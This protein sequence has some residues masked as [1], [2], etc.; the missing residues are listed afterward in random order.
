M[1]D[2]VAVLRKTIGGLEHNTPEA[3]EKVFAKARNAIDSKLASMDPPPPQVVADRQRKALEDAIV[4]VRAEYEPPAEDNFED[5]LGAFESMEPAAADLAARKPDGQES[6]GEAASAAPGVGYDADET[7]PAER[8]AVLASQDG[9]AG[10]AEPLPPHGDAAETGE[11][12]DDKAAAAP[13]PRPA[14]VKRRRTGTLAIAAAL[15]L[16][17]GAGAYA[18]WLNPDRV[19]ALFGTSTPVETVATDE[20]DDAVIVGEDEAEP[21]QAAETDEAAAEEAEKFTQRLL[22][23]GSEVDEGP[24]GEQ[25]R[26]GEGTSVATSTGTSDEQPASGPSASGQV[27]VGQ[28]AIFYEQT[29]STAEGS[30][31][32]GSIVWSLVQESPG[33]D[34]PPEP[35]IRGEV[36][37]PGHSL[38]LRM[39]IRRNADQ[40]LP[41]GHIM[42]MIF[43]TPENFA[44]G[45]IDSVLRVA[46]K[47]TEEETGNPLLGI[48]AK[49][50]DGFFL[51][52]LSD[53]PA[54][55]EANVDLL[56]SQ[57][58]I[59]VPIIYRSGRR[60]LMTMEKGLTG[61][62]VFNE[63]IEAWQRQTSG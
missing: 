15:I 55:M 19:T 35:A 9:A 32:T 3:R 41:A 27:P 7:P 36:T 26:I 4:A 31:E 14:G 59:D 34:A 58:W 62:R 8:D 17:I 63:A 11:P 47:G 45:A 61:E 5:F 40:T 43:L 25:R 51:F 37:I 48:P 12:T 56:R 20:G 6:D 50:A 22:P 38:Q 16:L 28:R 13:A 2:F 52:A 42:E 29:T 39:T 57:S 53:T 18:Y 44:G 1:A 54:E 49:I 10:P 24:A 46:M 23:D 21:V 60:A 30:A 33:G